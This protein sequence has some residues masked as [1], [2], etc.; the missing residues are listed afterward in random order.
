MVAERLQGELGSASGTPQI[1]GGGNCEVASKAEV[2][3]LAVPFESAVATIA[4]AAPAVSAQALWVDVTVPLEFAAGT[5]RAYLP[6]GVSA[7][8]TLGALVPGIVGAFKAVPA[9]ALSDLATA[10]DCDVF[11]CGDSAENK[12]RLIEVV[13]RV[14]G[15]RAV[16]VGP[17]SCARTLESMTALLIG[18]NRLHG[19]KGAHFRLKGL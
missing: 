9:R 8:E 18:V 2:L 6:G 14:Q 19:V 1:S 10:L 11:V 16:D 15:M 12:A 3:F 4:E 13:S 17:L 5:A 7:T